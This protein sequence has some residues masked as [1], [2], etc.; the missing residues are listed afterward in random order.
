[1]KIR[2]GFVSNS[3]SSSFVVFHGNINRI[4]LDMLKTVI[5]DFSDWDKDFAAKKGSVRPSYAKWVKN[6]KEALKRDDIKD[7]K[8]G[9]VMP[10]TN[11][12]TYLILKNNALFITTSNNHQWNLLQDAEDCENSSSQYEQIREVI[13]GSYFYDIR[14]KLIHS[15][16]KWDGKKEK[17]DCP[18]CDNNYGNYVCD[19]NGNMICG[20]CLKGKLGLSEEKIEQMFQSKRSSVKNPITTLKISE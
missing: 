2:N 7:G 8:I 11:Y 9:I 3:S 15:S 14:S 5:D 16:E 12:D 1:M 17:F 20:T 6:L 4:S 18:V 10:S 19:Q 13:H